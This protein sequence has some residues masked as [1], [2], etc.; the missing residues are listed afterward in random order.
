MSEMA[1]E[2][3]RKAFHMLSLVYLVAYVLLG[4]PRVIS[5][6][7]PWTAF[8]LAA[9]TARL[10]SE[11]LNRFLF[12]WLGVLS[13]DSER[14]NYSGIT[15]TTLGALFLF[16]A[17]GPRPAEVSTGM[18]CVAFGDTAA[19]LVGKPL[20]RHRILGSKK[21]VEGSLACFVVCAL[22]GVWQGYPS[23]SYLPAALAGTVVEFLPTTPWFNDN[24]WMP[25]AVAATLSLC[26]RS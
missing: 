12:R 21:S 26:A 11:N 4:Y 23:T 16:L 20:G 9:E 14:K 17:F 19:A 3:A 6:M 13:R 8:V 18:L 7:I 1:R 2:L 22:A 10:Y 15:H 5:W 24:C 25:I